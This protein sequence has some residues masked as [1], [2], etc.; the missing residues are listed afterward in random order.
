MNRVDQ[1]PE[2]LARIII[3]ASN[4]QLVLSRVNERSALWHEYNEHRAAA[5]LFVRGEEASARMTSS[6]CA[7]R[8]TEGAHGMAR[9]RTFRNGSEVPFAVPRSL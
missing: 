6:G 1:A 5:S 3:A 2:M 4:Y 9:E 7:R 8:S